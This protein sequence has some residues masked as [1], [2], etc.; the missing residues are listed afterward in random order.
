MDWFRS[1]DNY[2]E[3]IDASYWSEPANAITNAAFVIA[4]IWAWRLASR[5][6]DRGGQVLAVILGLIGIGSYLFHTHA[7]IWSL[8]ADVIPIQVFILVY[9]Y[10]A[11]VRFFRVPWWGGV[12]AVVAFI[13][14]AALTARGL[15]SVVGSLNGSIGYAPVPILIAGYA[16]LLWRSRPQ[17]ARGLAVGAGILVV[18]LIFRSLDREVCAAVPLGTHFMWHILNAVMLGWMIRVI[19]RP[20]EGLRN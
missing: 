8:Y 3:R 7:Q 14:Y 1:V 11:T 12:L 20:P 19:V 5:A 4:A 13:P 9:V 6:G 16:A 17:A 2:C 18:S 15:S 10:L